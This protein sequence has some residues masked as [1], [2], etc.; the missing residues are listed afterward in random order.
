LS[1]LPTLLRAEEAAVTQPVKKRRFSSDTINDL[2]FWGFHLFVVAVALAII[3]YK[4]DKLSGAIGQL[5]NAQNQ[6]LA[7]VQKQADAATESAIR[8]SQAEHTRALQFQAATNVLAGVLDKV[9]K[10][11]EDVAATLNQTQ[12]ISQTVLD[13]SL[14]AKSASL[15]A[16]NAASNA[17]GAANSA[18]GAAGAAASRA[19]STQGLVRAKVVTTQDK[20]RIEQEQRA[21]AAK[22]AQLS[23]TIRQ[24]RKNG[25][26][27]LQR[28]FQ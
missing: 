2:L 24:V 23:K 7:I 20:V 19:A 17:A 1:E 21:L 16:A 18:A 28:L 11:Q 9:S 4:I 3:W 14:Q 15:Q 22:R 10:I 8:A 27:I 5:L 25:P 12:G 26:N 13:V 6:E